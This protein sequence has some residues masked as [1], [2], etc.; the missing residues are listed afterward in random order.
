MAVLIYITTSVK[1]TTAQILVKQNM[2]GTKVASKA[3][4]PFPT[5]EA[6]M[7]NVQVSLVKEPHDI[8]VCKKKLLTV[9]SATLAQVVLKLTQW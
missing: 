3:T 2:K 7:A 8:L 5:N 9:A 4:L 1:K 6:S